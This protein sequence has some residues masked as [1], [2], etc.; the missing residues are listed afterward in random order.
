[1]KNIKNT[2]DELLKRLELLKREA[3]EET[4][5]ASV[6]EAIQTLIDCCEYLLTK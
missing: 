6:A 5:R 4:P 1:M 2:N 3:N